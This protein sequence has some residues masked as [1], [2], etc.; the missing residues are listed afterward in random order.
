MS[1]SWTSP[2]PHR[3]V[4]GTAFG[5]PYEHVEPPSPPVRSDVLAALV[6]LAVP[7][8]VAAPVGLGWAALAPRAVGVLAG[9]RYLQAD[10]SSD[11]F[12]AGDG[13]FLAAVLL[14]GMVTG[15]TAWSFGQQ[16]GPAVVTALA[17][18]GVGAALI[19]MRVG[20]AVG[21]EALDRAVQGGATRID[22]ALDLGAL[23]ALAG[24]PAAA[25]LAYLAATLVRGRGHELSSG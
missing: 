23:A 12:I 8:L 22:V 14:A 1:S 2:D 21:V 6:T 19:A 13:Y 9:G 16:H 7:L 11:A 17:V 20:E 15:L 5:Q 18:G 3:V 25:V 24:W 4:T 10:P